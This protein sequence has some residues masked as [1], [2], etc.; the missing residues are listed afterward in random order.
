MSAWNP[1]TELFWFGKDENDSMYLL[2]DN[3]AQAVANEDDWSLHSL[4]L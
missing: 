2:A 1:V 4:S 3:A